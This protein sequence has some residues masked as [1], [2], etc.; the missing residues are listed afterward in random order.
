M[1][2]FSGP[3]ACEQK[4][5]VSSS[6]FSCN[7]NF[8]L[9]FT[10]I[11]KRMGVPRFRPA[12]AGDG[13]SSPNLFVANCGPAVGLSYEA[14]ESVFSSFG[15]VKGVYAAD[16]SGARVIVSYFDE[17]CAQNALKSLNGRPCPDLGGRSLYIR[18]SILQPATPRVELYLK[19]NKEN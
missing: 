11:S 19:K 7:F 9:Y 5:T 2:F 15:A 16:E 17:S 1:G 6:T 3:V 8:Q 18:Y 13:G 4:N 14:I 12:K 10:I